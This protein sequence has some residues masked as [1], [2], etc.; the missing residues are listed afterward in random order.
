MQRVLLCITLSVLTLVTGGM[1]LVQHKSETNP[2]STWKDHIFKGGST[3][4]YPWLRAFFSSVTFFFVSFLT[5]PAP[6]CLIPWT[7]IPSGAAWIVAV[8]LG[9]IMTLGALVGPPDAKALRKK[10]E[11]RDAEVSVLLDTDYDLPAA[12]P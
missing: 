7:P 9:S 12:F 10:K 8:L 2:N 4:L 11:A 6:Q 5:P 1:A 3:V